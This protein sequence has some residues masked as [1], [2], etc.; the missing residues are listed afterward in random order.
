[1]KTATKVFLILTIISAA[2][3]M[4]LG[5]FMFAGGIGIT[6]SESAYTYPDYEALGAGITLMIG[7]GIYFLAPLVGLIISAVALSKLDKANRADDISTGFKVVVLIF[8]NIISGI[9]LL[10][11]KD[12]DFDSSLRYARPVPPPPPPYGQAPYNQPPSGEPTSYA[13]QETPKSENLV[14]TLTKY[15]QLLD[16]GAITEEEYNK[17]KREL[18]K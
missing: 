12:E 8:S 4:L 6:I 18:L 5:L 2:I 15:K 13:R 7:G 16:M 14:E 9:L 17:L 11:M 10:C 3:M 1:M